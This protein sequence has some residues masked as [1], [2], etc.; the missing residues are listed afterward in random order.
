MIVPDQLNEIGKEEFVFGRTN[1]AVA[2]ISAMRW[3]SFLRASCSLRTSAA[4]SRIGFA[5]A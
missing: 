1:E 4:L 3:R 2:W 5:A